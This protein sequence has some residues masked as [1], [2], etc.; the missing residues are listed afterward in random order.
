MKRILSITDLSDKAE[1]TI[2]YGSMLADQFNSEFFICFAI[3]IP[4]IGL[5]DFQWNP[6]SYIDRTITDSSEILYRFLD[7]NRIKAELIWTIDC[8]EKKIQA[9]VNDKKINLVVFPLK[10]RTGLNFYFAGKIIRLLA[11]RIACP[12]LLIPYINIGQANVDTCNLRFNKILIGCGSSTK[13]PSS[14][15]QLIRIAEMFGSELH[16]FIASNQENQDKGSRKKNRNSLIDAIE[17][18]MGRKA[19]ILVKNIKTVLKSGNQP[20]QLLKY[21]KKNSIDLIFLDTKISDC[22]ELRY[23]TSYVKRIISKAHCPVLLTGSN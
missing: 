17:E 5:C 13:L 1:L 12:L 14:I 10:I 23:S 8:I 19:E 6:G 4:N 16:F 11:D 18:L 2:H 7:R 3:P 21:I 9:V 20:D 15:N 22:G